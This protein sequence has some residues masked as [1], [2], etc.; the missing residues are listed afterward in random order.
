MTPRL[1]STTYSR[2]LRR[3]SSH[4][5]YFIKKLGCRQNEQLYFTLVHDDKNKNKR[6]STSLIHPAMTLHK[7]LS[8]L[9]RRTSQ[10]T[11][12]TKRNKRIH[13]LSQNKKGYAVFMEINYRETR[14]SDFKKIR[15]QFIDVDL[16]KISM[17]LDTKEQVK[18]MIESIHS[19]PEEQLQSIT[20]KRNKKGQYHL[21]ALRSKQRV[22]KLKKAFIK[23]FKLQIKDTMI[24]ETKNGYHIYWVVQGASVS[25]F[26]PIQKALA[27]KFS[28]DPLITNLS[29][30]MR[31]PGFYHMKNPRS[32]FIVKVR[33]LGRKKPFSQEEIIQSLALKP[34]N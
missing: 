20:V 8:L 14:T 22:T 15:A 11:L 29:R 3:F 30:V 10:F 19:D 33:Q 25:K 4:A 31:I 5:S 18:Q 21:L 13:V 28:S 24:I 34:F 27:Q 2:N 1:S 23:K 12:F 9:E 16:N 26:V 7:P 17:H 6:Y 32:P